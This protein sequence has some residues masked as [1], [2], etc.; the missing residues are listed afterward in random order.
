MDQ[1]LDEEY[2]WIERDGRD[3]NGLDQNINGLCKIK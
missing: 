3:M 2:K 1:T